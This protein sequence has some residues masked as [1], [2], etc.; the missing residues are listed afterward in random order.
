MLRYVLK[1]LLLVLPT[2]WIICSLVFLLSKT[3][4]G[5]CQDWQ[6]GEIGQTFSRL[7]PA[8]SSN[9]LEPIVPLFYFS[10]RSS[11]EPDTLFRVQPESHRLF[12]KSFVLTS[13]NW[14]AIAAFYQA[15]TTLQKRL[16]LMP[17]TAL[18]NKQ[19]LKQQLESVFTLTEAKQMQQTL[20]QVERQAKRQQLPTHFI[21]QLTFA[22]HQLKN[23]QA[24]P[25]RALIPALTWH[26]SNNQYYLWL[27][28]FILG[29][30]GVSC[31]DQ[32]SV[33]DKIAEAFSNTFF[34][35]VLS[36]GL[37]FFLAFE[38]S[39]WLNKAS[40]NKWR[41]FTLGI[42]YALDSVP[43]FIMALALLTLLASDA[44][45]NIFPPYGSGRIVAS[46]TPSYVTWIYQLPYLALPVISLTIANLPYVTGQIHQAVQQLQN[47]EFILTAKAKGL[48]ESVV[49]R[50][51]VLRNALLP[52]ITLFTGFLP[53]LV[54][55]SA[56]IEN[57]FSIPGMGRLLV[58]TVL[59]RDFPVLMGIVLYLGFIKISA[60]I[61]ADG[62][63][64]LADPR[65]R[66]PS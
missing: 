18:T 17:E 52:V 46:E 37:L 31:R 12:L 40:Q 27:K 45:F 58:E 56:V 21:R 29:D 34:I 26:G 35:T 36:L 44:Y 54:T 65:I 48:S 64:F 51:H 47:R 2:L 59:A 24:Q 63:Y 9:N 5:T 11:A 16:Q 8:R 10:L 20:E 14:A 32:I 33:N 53:A 6:Q 30:L 23:I 28:A 66:V 43:L 19:E 25:V 42:L 3:V 57:I 4:S 38:I 60:N 22:Q 61:L 41:R 62:F 7:E 39:I 55:G 50:R 49:L 15:L 13:G 1:R